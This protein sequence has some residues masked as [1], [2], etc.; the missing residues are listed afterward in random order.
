MRLMVTTVYATASG[1]YTIHTYNTTSRYILR[2][3]IKS[4]EFVVLNILLYFLSYGSN[5]L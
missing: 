2:A 1:S 4:N 3:V 5:S